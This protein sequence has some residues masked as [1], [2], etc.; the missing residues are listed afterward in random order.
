MADGILQG[1]T[2]FVSGSSSGIGR[3]IATELAQQGAEVFIHGRDL[4][5]ATAVADEIR[6]K[7]GVT[8][9]ATGDL[10]SDSGAQ[11]VA[12]AVRQTGKTVDILVNVAG[13]PGGNYGWSNSPADVWLGQFQ[14][15]ALTAVRLINH[16][17]PAMRE[18]RWGRIIQISSIAADH[19]LADQVPAYC[20]S[21][22]SLHA[23]TVS[24]AKTVTGEGVT[25]NTVM[26]GFTLTPA[27]QDYFMGLPD[28]AGKDW[29]EVER[30]A[31]EHLQIA[32]G[33]LG[34]PEEI[35]DVVAFLVSPRAGW[36]SGSNFRIDGCTAGHVG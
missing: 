22:A 13:G 11:E 4:G 16:F 1:K 25:V 14:L 35:A 18:Q 20:A 36:I 29:D 19:P 30:A 6:A 2:A 17:L 8:H 5:R 12:D 31:A 27:L 24:L 3:A 33:R 9:V 28:N 7:G 10:E 34:R 23:L 32:A 26:P 21:K 15:N